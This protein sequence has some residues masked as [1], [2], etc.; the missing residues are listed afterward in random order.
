VAARDRK[1]AVT[2]MKR[3]T[4]G[5]TFVLTISTASHFTLGYAQDA[6]AGCQ[7]IADCAQ[8]LVEIANKLVDMNQQLSKRVAQLEN[9]LEK[10]KSQNDSTLKNKTDALQGQITKMSQSLLVWGQPTQ[11]Q[12][13]TTYAK[14]GETKCD[15]GSYVVGV[16][17]I[18]ASSGIDGIRFIC[19]KLNPSTN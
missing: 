1:G 6:S 14:E 8:R 2:A 19:Y 10:Y 16:D 11:I 9:E 7:K 17:L 5:I 15:G 4:L 13:S 18:H 3:L 12:P